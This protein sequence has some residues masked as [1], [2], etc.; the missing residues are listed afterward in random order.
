[1]TDLT[2]KEA[3]RRLPEE[4]RR[5][6]N[7]LKDTQRGAQKEEKPLKGHPRRSQKGRRNLLK[8]TQEEARKG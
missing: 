6:R 3:Q 1:L 7:H 4:P 5:R 8:D 2:L